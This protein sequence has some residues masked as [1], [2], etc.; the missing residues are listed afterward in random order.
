MSE[1]NAAYLAQYNQGRPYK[2]IGFAEAFDI[3][4]RKQGTAKATKKVDDAQDEEDKE[5]RERG[6]EK[7]SSNRG[8]STSN[9]VKPTVRPGTTT[10]DI[11]N[12]IDNDDSY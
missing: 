8:M 10:R 9:L 5:R 4:E 1:R 6:A 3:W 12:R 11:L 7:G 2:H